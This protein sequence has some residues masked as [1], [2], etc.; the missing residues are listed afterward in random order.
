[1]LPVIDFDRPVGPVTMMHYFRA[2]LEAVRRFDT[3]GVGV[4]SVHVR[5]G[6][7]FVRGSDGTVLDMW[8]DPCAGCPLGKRMACQ[9]KR[10]S[11]AG[12]QA[13]VRHE[14]VPCASCGSENG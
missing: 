8:V 2:L 6:R 7:M 11:D 14:V 9:Q 1:M 10:A 12:N 13:A 4:V 3:S 5:K